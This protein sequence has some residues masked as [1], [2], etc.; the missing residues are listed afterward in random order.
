[1]D[2]S[3]HET[4]TIPKSSI[5]DM[6]KSG[7]PVLI[8][9]NPNTEQNRDT[10]FWKISQNFLAQPIYIDVTHSWVEQL[11][12]TL[13]EVENNYQAALSKIEVMF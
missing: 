9:A 3:Y 11:P 7:N 12:I 10:T 13:G 4:T 1:M 5:A 8:A 6:A 2:L